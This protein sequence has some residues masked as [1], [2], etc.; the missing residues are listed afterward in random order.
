[1]S[2]NPATVP[3]QAVEPPPPANEAQMREALA[4]ETGQRPDDDKSTWEWLWEAIQGDFN[5]KRSTGQIAFDAAVSM[6]PGVD[7]ICDV[8]DIIANCRA[9]AQSDEKDDNTWLWVALAL[10]LIGLIPTL[11]SALKG[12]LKIVFTFVRREGAKGLDKAID[13][14]MGWVITLLRKREVQAYLRSKNVD[15]VF[16]WLAQRVRKLQK[17][18]NTRALL[19][20]FDGAIRVTKGLLEKV[21][22]L[23]KVGE[24]AKQAIA[25]VER[26][27]LM[28]P[29]PL[30]KVDDLLQQMLGAVAR[31]FD[32]EHLLQRAGILSTTNVH[33]RGTLPPAQAVSLMR[34]SDPLPSWLS[35]GKP[36]KW[37]PLDPD[38]PDVLEALEEAKRMA[39]AEAQAKAKK[40]GLPES[41]VPVEHWPAPSERNIKSFH[42]LNPDKIVG[43]A[44]L[45]RIGSP[46]SPAMGDCWVSEEVFN[47]IMN[48]PDPKAAWRKYLGVWP[49][50]NA[51]GQFFVYEI[52]QGETLKVWRG[53]TASQVKDDI[54]DFDAHLEGG[55][56]QV[57]F[58]PT[59]EN[60]AAY[61]T[62][63][64]YQR[65]G[66]SGTLKP[67]SMS[68]TEYLNLPPSKQHAYT[69]VREQINARI[70]G[71]YDTHWGTTDFD[72][73]LQDAKIGLPTLPGQVTNAK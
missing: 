63:R 58:K 2:A 10:T 54:P 38:N 59:K 29:Q 70:D 40:L 15:E 26:V 12:V 1:M 41:K 21:T 20:E 16:S 9:I 67:S 34:K 57:V 8:R 73:Q 22:W 33:F 7:Q 37:K 30:A 47:K 64:V 71:P 23:P 52:P 68:Y 43:P 53:E 32:K 25:M 66:N 45:Y 14:S 72:P 62:M 42:K 51:N 49:D 69:P 17:E 36:G 31:R 24:K 35:K 11:G 65:T 27:R 19:A 48:S 18:V 46:S 44:R 39:V 5:D 50:W 6:I 4:W 3:P 60:G 56:E 28:A 55:W 61:D 13:L